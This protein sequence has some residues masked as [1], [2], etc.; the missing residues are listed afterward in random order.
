MD[1]DLQCISVED[2]R[3]VCY[4]SRGCQPQFLYS[5]ASCLRS[6]TVYYCQ[7]MDD[8]TVKCGKYGGDGRWDPS[9]PEMIN[10]FLGLPE[11]DRL[12]GQYVVIGHDRVGITAR[13]FRQLDEQFG[14]SGLCTD[15]KNNN[16]AEWRPQ[17]PFKGILRERGH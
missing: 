13:A 15:L 9:S 1:L 6:G 11:D 7:F 5:C 3:C 16:R 2:G 12:W 8:G 14:I 10:D 17:V 4:F